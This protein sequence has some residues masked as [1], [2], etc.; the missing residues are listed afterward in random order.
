ME[1]GGEALRV[2]GLRVEGLHGLAR[3]PKREPAQHQDCESGEGRHHGRARRGAPWQSA[4]LHSIAAERGA[5]L[6]G[7]EA[8][9]RRK[10]H[11]I[12]C[13]A[14]SMAAERLEGP[15]IHCMKAERPPRLRA[16]QTTTRKKQSARWTR[17]AEADVFETIIGATQE[18]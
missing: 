15:E 11:E 5:A 7:I 4:A 2:E 3:R 1:D 16:E 14:R 12:C 13:R 18:R 8:H 9:E 10:S 6:H 17:A